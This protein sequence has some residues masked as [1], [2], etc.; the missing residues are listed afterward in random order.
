M[1]V[2]KDM[3][4]WDK[5]KRMQCNIEKAIINEVIMNLTLKNYNQLQMELVKSPEDWDIFNDT[6]L[7]LTYKYNP[8]KD[9][10]EQFK[11][12]FNQLKG[13]YYRDDKCNH[14]YTLEEDRISIPD[15]IKDEENVPDKDVDLITKLKA[16]CH[17]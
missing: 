5:Y 4:N 3:N 14:F 13:A 12:L 7:K 2:L 1:K 10:K 6:Y 17:I 9:F 16:I 11:W 8:N 15:F